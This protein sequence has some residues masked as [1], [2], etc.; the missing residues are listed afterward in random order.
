MF[1]TLIVLLKTTLFLGDSFEL[2]AHSI[3]R[4]YPSVKWLKDGRELARTNQ[5][6]KTRL[7]GQ[8]DYILAVDC[9]VAKTSGT[10]TFVATNSAGEIRADTRIVI[11]RKV[12]GQSG[13]NEGEA[14]AF[15][16]PLADVIVGIGKPLSLKCKLSGQPAPSVGWFFTSDADQVR[17]LTD[18]NKKIIIFIHIL[19]K[20]KSM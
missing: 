16:E 6:Y 7:N 5:I 1:I 9:V 3:G 14:P 4:P 8:G 20:E 13:A 12:G 15:Q 17:I 18:F 2:L 19:Y 11:V 10:F